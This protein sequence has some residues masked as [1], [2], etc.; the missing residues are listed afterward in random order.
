MSQQ[1]H[2]SFIKTPKQL[3]VAV[4]FGFAVPIAIAVLAAQF[5][6]AGKKGAPDEETTARAIAP[7]A[8]LQLGS[9]KPAA[10]GPKT[11][12]QVYQAVCAAC[13]SSGAAGAPK[14]GDNGA[15]GPRLGV[16]LE[17]LVKS[18][19]AGKGAMPP[20]GGGADLSELELAR[21]IVFMANQS[22]ANFKEPAAPEGEAK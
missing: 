2:E 5:V 17:G 8:K 9:S 12:E 15:W 16:G 18:A 22:G 10:S 4:I 7:V 3:I 21:A 6:T 20:K 19:T 13:H 14:T 1:E 11:G